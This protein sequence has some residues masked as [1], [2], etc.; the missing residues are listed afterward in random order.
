V[1]GVVEVQGWPAPRWRKG[2]VSE[3]LAGMGVFGVGRR[4]CGGGG[5]PVGEVDVAAG[6]R[7]DVNGTART[8]GTGCGRHEIRFGCGGGPALSRSYLGLHPMPAGVPLTETLG[9]GPFPLTQPG[10]KS[11]TTDPG[12]RRSTSIFVPTGG[13]SAGAG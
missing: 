5:A 11:F 2:M 10:V 1:Q 8:P 6:G 13:F 12:L 3:R 4:K 7:F 9:R